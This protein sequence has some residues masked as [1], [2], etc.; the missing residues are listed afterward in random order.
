[1]VRRASALTALTSSVTV[2]RCQA[3]LG[4]T[5]CW[6]AHMSLD[7]TSGSDP[8][9]IAL[10]ASKCVMLSYQITLRNSS[11]SPRCW[12]LSYTIVV[13]G[14]QHAVLTLP[15]RCGTASIVAL[16]GCGETCATAALWYAIPPCYRLK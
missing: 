6:L 12:R 16:R 4:N 14:C 11:S 2:L 9:G 7:Q 10:R 1:M 5:R 13:V 15:S 3:L 8:D